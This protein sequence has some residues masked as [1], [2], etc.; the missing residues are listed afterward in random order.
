MHCAW[1]VC[2]RV[3]TDMWVTEDITVYIGQGT[4]KVSTLK[5]DWNR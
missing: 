1:A 3:G 4:K 2:S 5:K